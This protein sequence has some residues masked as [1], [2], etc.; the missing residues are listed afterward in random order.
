MRFI[1]SAIIMATASITLCISANAASASWRCLFPVFAE[2][3]TYIAEL[4]T[5]KGK[6]V[7]NAGTSDV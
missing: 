6:V 2:P 5:R 4:G 7:G 3:T 1:L